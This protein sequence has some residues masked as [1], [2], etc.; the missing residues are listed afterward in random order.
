MQSVHTLI[1]GGI[2]PAITSRNLEPHYATTAHNTRLR[3][4]S[5]RPISAPK[6]IR[7]EATVI[8]GIY[9]N[10]D[11]E[12]CCGK[13]L[14]WDHCV[15]VIEPVD[16]GCGGFDGV[17]V[18]HHDQCK[19]E[20]QR[21]FNCEDKWYPLV[22]PQPQRP[23]IA[24]RTVAGSVPLDSQAMGEVSYRGPDSRSY[25]YTWVDRFGVESPPSTPSATFLAYDDETWTVTGFDPP[26]PN[27]AAIRIYRPGGVLEDGKKPANPMDTTF[28]LVREVDV[29]AGS[30][31]TGTFVDNFRFIDMTYGTLLTEED[32]PPPCMDQVVM[33]EQGYAVGFKGNELFVSERNEPHNFPEKYRVTIAEKIVAISVMVDFIMVGT[34]GRPYRINTSF[35]RQGNEASLTVDPVPF[36]EVL[37]CLSR[38]AFCATP[39]GAIY[40][41]YESLVLIAPQGNATQITRKRIDEQDWYKD[42]APNIGV[43][44]DG[45]MHLAR[46]P[47]GRATVIDIPDPSVG[48]ELDLG[49]MYTTDWHPRTVHI[50]RRGQLLYSEGRSLYEWE[51]GQDVLT[52]EW[53]S[54]LFRLP[55]MVGFGAMK[56]LGD[57]GPPIALEVYADG[58]L[59]HSRQVKS[60]KPFRLPA[61]GRGIEWQ[62]RL[63]GTTQ[64]YEVQM[65]TS[66]RDLAHEKGR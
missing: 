38:R 54:K 6:L 4:G 17:V 63:V 51:S 52:Y 46:S 34:T 60:S 62:Y 31:W 18:Y 35:A 43:F 32:C 53:K 28:Q 27:A 25:V 57:F 15:S 10:R 48:R 66:V 3:D 5:L 13:I 30:G 58:K 42:F 1:F 37:P 21:Y 47:V 20:P 49:D 36:L 50:G 45:R 16:P 23:A 26:P 56:V 40:V 65:A 59:Y 22:V 2:R 39:F 8:E 29:G 24:T 44:H 61:R 14:T 19:T 11:S 41:S 12:E 9:H 7:E 64:V 33:T 55:G